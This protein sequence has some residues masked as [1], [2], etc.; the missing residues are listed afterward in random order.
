MISK[1]KVHYEGNITVKQ[2]MVSA[3]CSS[4][5]HHLRSLASRQLLQCRKKRIYGAIDC[6]VDRQ[7]G[8]SPQCMSI[9]SSVAKTTSSI[10]AANICASWQQEL[11]IYVDNPLDFATDLAKSGG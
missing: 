3:A 5:G 7:G 1:R 2:D 11:I 9:C 6:R 4:I 8:P 10:S